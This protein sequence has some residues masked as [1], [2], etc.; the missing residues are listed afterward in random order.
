MVRL[1]RAMPSP[2]DTWNRPI[3]SLD[4]GLWPSR[5]VDDGPHLVLLGKD[6]DNHNLPNAVSIGLPAIPSAPDYAF[7]SRGHKLGPP[8]HDI[9]CLTDAA[10]NCDLRVAGNLSADDIRRVV[11]RHHARFSF[12]YEDGLKKDKTLAGSASFDFVIGRDGSVAS[13]RT[14]KS[15]L[16]NK[17]VLACVARAFYGI[18]FPAPETGIVT[19][20]YPV[21]FYPAY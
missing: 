20:S 7:P 19:V 17:E 9:S 3:A 16:P 18:T 2:P 14:G 4:A 15:D 10:G 6:Q 11:R 13:V 21:T 12:C 5:F 8:V 1:V